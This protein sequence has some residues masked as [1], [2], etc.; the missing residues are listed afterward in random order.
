MLVHSLDFVLLMGNMVQVERQH[1]ESCVVGGCDHKGQFVVLPG[2]P[3]S[4]QKVPMFIAF[5]N[6][7]FI[8]S[9]HLQVDDQLPGGDE[10][11]EVNVS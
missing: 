7:Y 1:H 4:S 8:V 11:D 9:R 3:E 5:F 6:S 10:V 2:S